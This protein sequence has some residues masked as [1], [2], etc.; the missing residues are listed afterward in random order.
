MIYLGYQVTSDPSSVI[1]K[2]GKKGKEEETNSTKDCRADIR[3]TE[4]GLQE[5]SFVNRALCHNL[6]IPRDTS[7]PYL[8]VLRDATGNLTSF[9]THRTSETMLISFGLLSRK[10]IHAWVAQS[11]KR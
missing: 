4:S 1:Q 9:L 6:V 3:S 10:I 5:I 7:T 8:S 2:E 11:Q